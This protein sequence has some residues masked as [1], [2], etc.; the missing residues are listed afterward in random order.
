MTVMRAAALTG[1]AGGIGRAL[2]FGLAAQGCDLALA[3]RDA[4]GLEA[5]AITLRTTHKVAV[6]V[7]PLDVA[8]QQA[9]KAFAAA[10]VAAHPALNV[11]INNAGVTLL[12]TLAEI[13]LADFEWLMRVNFWGTVWG[14]HSFLPH[15]RAQPDAHIVNLSSVFGLIA[16][17]GQ[18]AYAASKFAVRGYTE[19]LRHET[20]G[21]TLKVTC[22]HPGGVRTD[23][24]RNARAAAALSNQRAAIEDRFARMARTAPE[25]AAARII[26]GIVANEPRIL[27][28]PDARFIDR[29]QRWMPVRYWHIMGRLMGRAA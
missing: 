20:A 11:L 27:I 14:C 25:T 8:D 2:A 9:V 7:H 28:G 26:R 3:D 12:G 10:A 1:A 4:A 21:T 29:L 17:P 23:I 13:D 19:A 18:A 16:P 6:S 15:L 5:V 22:V 24:A